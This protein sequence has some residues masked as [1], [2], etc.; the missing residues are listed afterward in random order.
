MTSHCLAPAL[1]RV[2]LL[3]LAAPMLACIV[4]E[5]PGFLFDTSTSAGAET[6]TSD[7][8]TTTVTS[9]VGTANTGVADTGTTADSVTD[10]GPGP[11]ATA[12]SDPATSDTTS[13]ATATDATATDAQTSSGG[14]TDGACEGIMMHQDISPVA[15][16]FFIS[17]GTENQTT[18]IYHDDVNGAKLPCK[19]LNFG[20][21]GALRLARMDGGIDAMFAV[22]FSIEELLEL[23]K[24]A[25]K[26]DHAELVMTLYDG[27]END[28]QFEVGLIQHGWTDGSQNGT[29]AVMGDSSFQSADIGFQ[30]KAWMGNDGPRGASM[31]VT[32]LDI[33]P[34]YVNHAE[35]ASGPF[36]VDA[37]LEDPLKGWGLVVA[38]PKNVAINTYGPG[39]KAMEAG[40]DY[41]PVLRVYYCAQ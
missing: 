22:R 18:C 4:A 39:F 32:T 29:L 38:F 11:T 21:T 31:K 5:N 40:L 36:G 2:V 28:I 41:Q 9:T 30:A 26:F 1:R 3:A 14:T 13:D 12:S 25:G 8:A 17:G 7:P 34:G 19:D 35:V 16:A 20:A 37:W 33:K 10:P 6:A 23:A 24:T 15:D 27:I